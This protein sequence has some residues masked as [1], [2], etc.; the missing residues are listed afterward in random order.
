LHAQ[1]EQAGLKHRVHLLGVRGDVADLLAA[2]D[3]FILPSLF[4]GLPL[5]LLEAMGAGLPVIATHVCGSAEVVQDG[6]SG[7]LVPPR[8]PPALAAAILEVLD[9]PDL[10][11]RWGAAAR[12]RVKRDFSARAMA[13]RVAAIYDEVLHVSHATMQAGAA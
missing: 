11:S 5:A 1:I 12:A 3:L 9:N 10:A 4:E 7:R 8:D 2:S 6:L 13:D